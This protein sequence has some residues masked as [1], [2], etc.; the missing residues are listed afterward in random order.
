MTEND[1]KPALILPKLSPF[2]VSSSRRLP[3]AGGLD[4][5]PPFAFPRKGFFMVRLLL[6]LGL[7]TL[8]PA[9]V[10]AGVPAKAKRPIKLEDLFRFKRVSD[11]QTSPDGKAVAYVV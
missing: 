5:P 7:M 4:R 8:L 3:A 1:Q 9:V 2:V 11:P 6:L 10:T